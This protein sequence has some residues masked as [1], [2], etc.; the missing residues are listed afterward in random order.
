MMIVVHRA[1]VIGFIAGA[2]IVAGCAS[3]GRSGPEPFPRPARDAAADR[4]GNASSIGVDIVR[5]ALD[6]RGTPYA[7][8]GSDTRGFDCSGFV[9]FVYGRH[10]RGTPREVSEL[11]RA[12][13]SLP[14]DRLQPGDLLFFRT[15]S[16][17][18]SH[19]AISLG[20]RRFVH[21]PSTGGVVRVEDLDVP[22]WARR[23]L[24]A[25]RLATD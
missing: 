8:G 18:A 25:R 5:T 15:T 7:F 21:A 11:F 22:Y 12:S 16:R 6:L 20:D 23:L 4:P 2:L 24:G 3:G 1:G 9:Q 14:L 13:T 19:V 17:G 10:G